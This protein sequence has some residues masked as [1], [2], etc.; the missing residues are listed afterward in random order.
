MPSQLKAG[1]QV[2]Q[3][4]NEGSQPHEVNLIKLAEGK[5]IEDVQTFLHAPNGAPVGPRH[6]FWWRG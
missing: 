2:W 3:I 4:F 5:T 1:R 6:Q